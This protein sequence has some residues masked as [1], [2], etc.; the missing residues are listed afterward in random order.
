MDTRRRPEATDPPDD[1]DRLQA[2]I[3]EAGAEAMRVRV[4]GYLT[5]SG[6]AVRSYLVAL[7]EL[8]LAA[9]IGA[10]LRAAGLDLPDDP[11]GT[12]ASL[13]EQLQRVARGAVAV[14]FIEAT[15][16]IVAGLLG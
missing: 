8:H 4:A 15:D 6:R 11:F 9:E 1:R 2:A 5:A 7:Q 3:I 14:G 16:P 10:D 12:P 13:F